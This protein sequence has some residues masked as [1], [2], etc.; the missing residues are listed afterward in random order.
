MD[1]LSCPGCGVS[2]PMREG[3]LPRSV[4]CLKCGAA[5]AFPKAP[6]ALPPL[7]PAEGLPPSLGKYAL[8]RQLGRGGLGFVY[9]A[10]H[11][12]TGLKVALKILDLV[13]SLDPRR[14]AQEAVLFTR[15]ARACASVPRHPAVVSITNAGTADGKYF[16]EMEFV[17]GVSMH[18][19]RR[20]AQPT[21]RR[22]IEVLRDV[23]LALEHI[24]R[25]GIV[26]RDLK[27]E[28][29]L[30]DGEDRP[31]VSD[32]GIA[33]ILGDK[34]TVSSGSEL[35]VG[36]PAYVS[37][38]QALKP[39]SADHR[40]D[41]Y[42]LGVMLYEALTGLLPF[43]GRSTVSLLMSVMNDPVAP[44]STTP[45]GKADPLGDEKMDE[46]CLKAL[47]KKPEDRYP[48]AAQLA[49]ALTAWLG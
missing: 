12:E 13:P 38:E 42:S 11:K 14:A 7:L 10:V 45:Q 33:R 25:H 9:E 30:V 44:P 22:Q 5:L 43:T 4:R 3:D 39:R 17:D 1:F 40:T 37:P 15:E 27:P 20:R 26:H 6:P 16:L 34:S 2:Y 28:N 23:A 24:H 18:E 49:D 48:T 31:H 21:L 46:I 35:L 41:V 32:F 47:A 19:W 36:T 29:V 8:V